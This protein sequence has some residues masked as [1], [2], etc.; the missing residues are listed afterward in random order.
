MQPRLPLE[1]PPDRTLET[2]IVS[3][4]NRAI[5]TSLQSWREWPG[6]AFALTGPAGAGKT[7][8]AQAW[9]ALTGAHVLDRE[10]SAPTARATFVEARGRVLIDGLEAG[11]DDAAVTLVLDLAREAGG[12]VLLVGRGPPE[13]WPT[14]TKDLAS[15]FRATPSAILPEPDLILLE[16][17]LRRLARARFIELP[18]GVARF[19]ATS[20]ER[21]FAAA[22][23]AAAALDELMLHGAKPVSYDLARRALDRV[24]AALPE[25]LS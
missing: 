16:K 9:A 18:P 14:H 5:W 24:A 17:V 2:L 4:C 12:G 8:M 23:A 19:M 7:H 22:N 6:G 1:P 25:D 10:A 15:R 13:A 11:C 21:S 20:M 3:E